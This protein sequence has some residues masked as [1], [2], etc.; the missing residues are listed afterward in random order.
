MST[1]ANADMGESLAVTDYSEMLETIDVAIE[2]ARS[3]IVSGRIRDVS[4]EKVRC[5]QWRTLGY[6][7]NVRRQV[8]NDRDLEALSERVEALEDDQDPALTDMLQKE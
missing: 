4:R 2:E 5:K 8:A 3:K 6:L 1:D 7:I